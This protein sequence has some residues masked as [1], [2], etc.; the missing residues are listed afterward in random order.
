MNFEYSIPVKLHFGCKK[1]SLVGSICK[2]YGKKV[3][4]V[5]GKKS[6]KKTGLL[7]RVVE[8]LKAEGLESVVFDEVEQNPL[9]TTV[10]AGVKLAKQEG[11]DVVLG[12][13]GGSAMDAAKAIAFSCVNEGDISDYIFGKQGYGA[14]P[15]ILVTT[16]AGTGSEADSIAVLTNPETKDKKALKSPYIY[17][18][19]SIIDP[20]LMTTM[21]KNVIA[22]T[23]FDALCHA[24]EGYLSSH[25]N[26]ITDALA[27]D[28]IKRISENLPK[29]YE[30]PSDIDSWNNMAIANTMAGMVLDSAG[31]TLVHGMEH[32]L[33]GLYGIVHGEG[34]A[35]LMPAAMQYTF[36]F[37]VE[38][39][40]NITLAMGYGDDKDD[41]VKL[42]SKAKDAVISLLEK[43]NLRVS[44]RG[45]GVKE[46]DIDWLT[47][48]AFKTMKHAIDKHPVVL[49]AD[50]IKYL[51][52][53][54]L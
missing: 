25:A 27:L 41:E 40:K 14:L 52:R 11:C 42:A 23:G 15:I 22:A 30:N 5:T 35:A 34:L 33:S 7:Y 2:K 13:G 3:L 29:V 26:P 46:E 10:E 24:I 36:P 20:E 32:P 43:I 51:Y 1:E 45:L 21:P 48:N 44:L 9:T 53:N 8:Y 39:C 16:T 38:K 17:P 50:E 19:E 12:L 18:K 37:A 54:C 6:T 31:A 47:E 4:I 49:G 28:V